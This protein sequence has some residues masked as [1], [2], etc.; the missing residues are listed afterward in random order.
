MK[1]E[2]DRL[3]PDLH[4]IQEVNGVNLDLIVALIVQ[5]VYLKDLIP[6]TYLPDRQV[7]LHKYPVLV[8]VL[9]NQES[10]H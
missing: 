2:I 7:H 10:G 6:R 8:Q 5:S 9:E 4:Q 1:T 3:I